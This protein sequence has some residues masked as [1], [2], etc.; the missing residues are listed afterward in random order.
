MASA[1]QLADPAILHD[2]QTA[3]GRLAAAQT[4]GGVGQA[5]LVE[6]ARDQKSR[7]DGQ[8]GG[9]VVAGPELSCAIG[10]LAPQ[11]A[12]TIQPITG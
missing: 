10:V 2:L 11:I 6:A 9:G 5:I 1:E 3:G 12:P 7:G 4:V 8:S